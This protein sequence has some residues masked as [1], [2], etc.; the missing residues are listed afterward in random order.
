M[1]V[2]AACAQKKQQGPSLAD[3]LSWM[4]HTYNPN[5]NGFGGHGLTFSKCSMDC[6]DI[7]TKISLR[8]TFAYNGCQISTTTISNRKN[9]QGLHETFNLR[10]IDPQSVRVLNKPMT[11]DEDGVQ[12]KFSTRNNIEALTYSGNITG[13]SNNSEW[14]VNDETYARHFA[15]AFRHAVELCGGKP[16]AFPSN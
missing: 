10:D 8:E 13:K 2:L 1:L 16:S 15:D 11:V 3:T 12:V 7:G 9:D 14:S 6:K 5:S 4:D